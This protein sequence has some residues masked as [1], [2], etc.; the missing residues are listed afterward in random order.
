VL[1]D[2]LLK[3]MNEQMKAEFYSAHL[4]LSMA[5]YCADEDLEGFENFF[6]AQGEE[7]RFH[8]MKFYNFINETG[9]RAVV[10]GFEDP[11]ADFKS[12]E[13]LFATSL[14]HE[15]KVTAL[16]SAIMD[17]AQDERNYAAISFLNWFVD[18]QVEEEDMFST[19]LGKVK[20]FGSGDA[21]YQLDKELAQRVFSPP[22]AEGE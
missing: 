1:S 5:A 16:I 20:R 13:D 6:I 22:V 10:Y 11:P 15:K 21:L 12:I 8:A 19:L 2:K 17:I 14:D 18:E 7:E 3:A 4:Y 9:G